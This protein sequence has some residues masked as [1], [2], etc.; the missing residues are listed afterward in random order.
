MIIPQFWA[1]A[2]RHEMR[3]GR[4]VTVRRHGWSDI[5]QAEAQTHADARAD[6]ALRRIQS[7]EHLPRRERKQAYNGADGMPIREE[8]ISRHGDAII[9]RNSYGAHCL[10]TPNVLFVDVD[11]RDGPSGR[12]IAAVLAA[13]WTAAALLGWLWRSW[14]LGA[15][16]ALLALLFGWLLANQAYRLLIWAGGSE[17]RRARTRIARF[18]EQRPDWHLRVYRTPAGF[19]LLAMH[20][21]FDPAEAAVAECFRELRA[22]PVYARMCLN[23]QCFRARVSPKPWRIGIPSHLKPNPGVWPVAADRLPQRRRWI[24]HYQ[25]AA[26]NY[27][28]CRYLESLGNGGIATAARSVQTLHDTLAQANCPLP[29]A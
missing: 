29:I 21:T 6:E 28:A 27:A 2:R 9:T 26:A 3:Q 23:Q 25:Q 7:G 24:D 22:D 8:I 20:R 5:S 18:I 11:F 12:M 16:L 4:S 1:E 13:G 15:G 19:R 10:N 17:E 14:G